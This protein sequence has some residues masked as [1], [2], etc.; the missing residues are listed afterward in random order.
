MRSWWRLSM[1]V[2]LMHLALMAA[3]VLWGRPQ[4][5]ESLQPTIR[6][7]MMLASPRE[8]AATVRPPVS[9]VRSSESVTRQAGPVIRPAPAVASRSSSTIGAV[10]ESASEPAPSVPARSSSAEAM[11]VADREPMVDASYRGNR[12]PE[13]P[14]LSRRLG[15]QGAVV[16]RVLITAEG[17][18][19]EVIVL[20]SSGSARLD[21]AAKATIRDWRFLPAV[22][23]TRPVPA[24]YEWRWEFRLSG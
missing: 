15:E 2:A 16:L 12:A 18:A 10:S 6:V 3:L 14:A 23:G 21:E 20:K 5:T 13:Y 22:R 8:S 1:A 17:R 9:A 24:W 4:I 11:G 7:Q 19:S